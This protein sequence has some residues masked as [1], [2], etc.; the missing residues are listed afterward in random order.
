MTSSNNEQ[1]IQDLE[2]TRQLI[3]HE[4]DLINHRL[5]WFITLQGLL[6]AA[7]AFAWDKNDAKGL[8]FVFCGLGILAAISTGSVLWGGAFAIENLSK[9]EKQNQR[10]QVIGRHAKWIEKIFYPWF[11]L[12]V[13]FA[14]AWGFILFLNGLRVT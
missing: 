2:V 9:A 10:S 7:L 6:L 5:T 13:L 8:V 14:I 11:S 1:P 12:P 4:N 3:Q